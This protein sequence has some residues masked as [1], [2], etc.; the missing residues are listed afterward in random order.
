[1]KLPDVNLLLYAFDEVSPHNEGA[2]AWLDETLSGS[3]TVALAWATLTGFLRL[4]THATIFEQPLEAEEA[5][6]II[7]GWLA[8][9]CTTVVHPTARHTAV[10]RELLGPL[11]T[12]G[13]LVNDAH[14]AALA[15]EHGAV[16]Y[17]RD[18]DFSR[19]PGLR[20]VDPLRA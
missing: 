3:E 13:N 8:Q 5:L 4:S 6:E 19:F 15:I 2:R 7:D 17:S 20:W 1:M 18:N 12:A 9:P 14:L 11:G 16:L 10:L